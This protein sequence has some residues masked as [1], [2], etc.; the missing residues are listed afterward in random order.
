M[1]W[2]IGKEGKKNEVNYDYTVEE[3][4]IAVEDIGVLIAWQYFKIWN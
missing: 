1:S 2:N 4:Y 3:K